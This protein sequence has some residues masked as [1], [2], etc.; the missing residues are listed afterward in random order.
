MYM[1]LS[2]VL[3]IIMPTVLATMIWITDSRVSVHFMLHL[4]GNRL[5]GRF[6]L[7]KNPPLASELVLYS[8][9]S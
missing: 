7:L 5:L 8:N 1:K 4:V 9:V 6:V 3:F 2:H